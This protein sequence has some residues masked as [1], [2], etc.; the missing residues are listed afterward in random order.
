MKPTAYLVNTSRGPV[1]D[2]VALVDALKNNVI[3]GAGLDVFENEPNLAPGLSDLPNVVI[4]PH[5]ASATTPAREGMAILAAKNIIDFLEGKVP[6]NK[7]T[8]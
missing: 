2:E 5:I 8:A 3:A 6:D 4:T 7:V 1:V